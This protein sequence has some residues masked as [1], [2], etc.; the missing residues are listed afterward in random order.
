MRSA[1]DAP[2]VDPG[3]MRS[4]FGHFATGVCVLGLETADGEAVG[5]T[6][7]SF[8]S[9]S[10]DPPLLLVCLG[11]FLRSHDHAVSAPGFG[12]SVL[13]QGQEEVSNR[14][15]TRDGPKWRGFD[16]I[17]GQR[18]GLLVPGALAH[19]DCV[20]ERTEGVGDHTLLIGR[21]VGCRAELEAG[22]LL[23]FRGRYDALPTAA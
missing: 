23:F 11:H 22:P 5:M 19:F 12:I 17:R 1:T 6:L 18:G 9:V 2:A 8:T 7:N 3:T 20:S 16:A 21:V 13:A 14:F 10:L 15:A 4:V